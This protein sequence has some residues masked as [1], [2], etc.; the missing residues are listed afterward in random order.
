LYKC[1][2]YKKSIIEKYGGMISP[3]EI[4]NVCFEKIEIKMKKEVLVI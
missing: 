4:A 2:I 3:I 1:E